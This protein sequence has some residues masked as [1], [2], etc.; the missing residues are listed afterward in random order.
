MFPPAGVVNP[1]LSSLTMTFVSLRVLLVPLL[2]LAQTWPLKFTVIWVPAV[3]LSHVQVLVTLMR[4]VQSATHE[5]LAEP[6]TVPEPEE[7]VAVTVTVS[8]GAQVLDSE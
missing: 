5:A 6:V 4:G 8:L 1:P 2:S 7:P 3:F